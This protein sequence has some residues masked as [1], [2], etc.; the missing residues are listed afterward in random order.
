[1]RSQDILFAW[2]PLWESPRACCDL[3]LP[4]WL[5]P[6]VGESNRSLP[7]FLCFLQERTRKVLFILQVPLNRRRRR[8]PDM[9][10]FC[11]R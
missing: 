3:N 9:G 6:D 5:F 11:P 7:L 4:L 2:P 1:M 8:G 10:R